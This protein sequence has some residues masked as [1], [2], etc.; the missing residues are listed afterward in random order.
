MSSSFLKRVSGLVLR[1]DDY[2]V[3]VLETGNVVEFN[4]TAFY[5]LEMLAE[6]NSVETLTADVFENCE[7]EGTKDEVRTMILEFVSSCKQHG[8]LTDV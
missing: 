3:L 5:L 8:I 6:P 4:E 2:K 7:V 1:P